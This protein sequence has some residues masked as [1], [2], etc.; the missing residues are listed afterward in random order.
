MIHLSFYLG[1]LRAKGPVWVSTIIFSL[2]SII[3][4]T[5]KKHYQLIAPTVNKKKSPKKIQKNPL[6]KIKKIP[7]K[8]NSPINLIF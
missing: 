7:F 1:Y 2:T 3:R 4:F 5:L 6:K 8:K